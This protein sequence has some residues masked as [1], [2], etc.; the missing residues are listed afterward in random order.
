MIENPQELEIRKFLDLADK[1]ERNGDLHAA[2]D[3][4]LEAQVM[5]LLFELYRRYNIDQLCHIAA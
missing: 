4:L 5:F 1:H 2:K 3:A